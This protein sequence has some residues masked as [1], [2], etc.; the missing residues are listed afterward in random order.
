[1]QS[2]YEYAIELGF[3]ELEAQALQACKCGAGA[4]PE[5]ILR[6]AKV[7]RLPSTKP[8][9]PVP[10]SDLSPDALRSSPSPVTI[11]T[12]SKPPTKRRKATRRRMVKEG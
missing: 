5:N 2:A 10:P 9:Y 8:D 7:K 11:P 3:T 12:S 4:S 1:M 6:I